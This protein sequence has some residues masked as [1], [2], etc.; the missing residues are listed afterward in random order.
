MSNLHKATKNVLIDV[1][2]VELLGNFI[3]KPL[4][5]IAV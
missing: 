5:H 3:H 1:E 2:V 4:R